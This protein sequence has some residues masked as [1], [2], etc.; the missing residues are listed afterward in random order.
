MGRITVK[1]GDKVKVGQFVGLSGGENGDH[2]HLE[3]RELQPLGNFKVVDPRKSFVAESLKEA[4]KA[5]QDTKDAAPSIANTATG[6]ARFRPLDQSLN[7][8]GAVAQESDNDDKYA[9]ITVRR[10]AC[11]VDAEGDIVAA[12]GDDVMSGTAFTVYNPTNHGK[13]RSTDDSGQATFGPRAGQNAISGD[14][15][16]GQFTGAYVSCQDDDTGRVLFDGTISTPSLT[17]DTEPGQRITCNWYD[18]SWLPSE[19]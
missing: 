8:V 16:N 7:V 2:L 1:V 12:C 11:P 4:A 3:T 5:A 10:V 14:D 13:T 9:R 15:G 17:I 6:E 18:L 19:S